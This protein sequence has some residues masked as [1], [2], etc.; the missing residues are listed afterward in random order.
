MHFWVFVPG[1]CGGEFVLV[2][3]LAVSSLLLLSRGQKEGSARRYLV[4]FSVVRAF[5]FFF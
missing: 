2:L 4:N 1:R 5:I 3:C